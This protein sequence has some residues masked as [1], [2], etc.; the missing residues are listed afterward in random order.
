[1]KEKLK[2]IGVKIRLKKGS[3]KKVQRWAK[4]LN[5]RIEEAMETLRDE[6]VF[7]E[8]AFLDRGEN[9]DYLIY[10]MKVKNLEKAGEI[11]QKSTHAIDKFHQAFKKECWVEGKNLELLIDFDRYHEFHE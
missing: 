3:L 4:E 7:L 5:H 9:D 2:T 11:A 6:G 8:A 10:F 1:M